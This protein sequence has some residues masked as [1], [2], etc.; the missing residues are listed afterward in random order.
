MVV[1][2]VEEAAR[3]Y[4]KRGQMSMEV[5]TREDLGAASCVT[6][7]VFSYILCISLPIPRFP[8]TVI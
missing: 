4:L 8:R 7:D 5:V 3:R 2:V 6:Y 1:G